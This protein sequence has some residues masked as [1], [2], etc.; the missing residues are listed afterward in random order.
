ML[1]W[2]KRGCYTQSLLYLTCIF[3]QG[4]LDLQ[5][6]VECKLELL[7]QN[8]FLHSVLRPGSHNMQTFTKLSLRSEGRQVGQVR[9]MKSFYNE[10][11]R[12]LSLGDTWPNMLIF[13]TI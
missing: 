5:G 2:R 10:N 6:P 1:T 9:Q 7:V 8:L 3:L 4:N 11:T 12:T 13:H